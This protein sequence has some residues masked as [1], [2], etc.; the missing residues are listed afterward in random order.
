MRRVYSDGFTTTPFP[1]RSAGN[2]GAASRTR[3]SG[4]FHG[5]MIPTTPRGIEV[6]PRA[7]FFGHAD[8]ARA[9]F[10]RS[11]PSIDTRPAAQRVQRTEGLV[12]D[13]CDGR[14][15]PSPTRARLDHLGA[16]RNISF[17]AALQR[18]DALPTSRRKTPVR[19]ARRCARATASRDLVPVRRDAD[20]RR[21]A[22][23]RWAEMGMISPGFST[24]SPLSVM[25]LPF[26]F[27]LAGGI[28]VAGPCHAGGRGARGG[29]GLR[30]VRRDRLEGRECSRAIS[31][32]ADQ[33]EPGAERMAER[34]MRDDDG[35][36]SLDATR[37]SVI[38]SKGRARSPAGHRRARPS[39][40]GARSRAKSDG[41]A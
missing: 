4:K 18:L 26:P 19:S 39:L 30:H 24:P 28:K 8:R 2:D 15:F 27:V 25:S 16:A 6:H 12:E 3:R 32:P 17:A 13:P 1:V 41:L 34:V 35:G 40:R 5:A 7:L 9:H 11:R 33:D 38:A 31:T 29:E 36:R 37:L 20:R 23:D 10:A 21:A 14:L 22:P